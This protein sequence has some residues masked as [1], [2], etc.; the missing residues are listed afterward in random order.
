MTHTLWIAESENG[1]IQFDSPPSVADVRNC[2]LDLEG[3]ISVYAVECLETSR[4]LVF[5]VEE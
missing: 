1:T 2:C 4:E 3:E 5:S